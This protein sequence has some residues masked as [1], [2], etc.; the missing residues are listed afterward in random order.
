MKPSFSSVGWVRSVILSATLLCGGWCWHANSQTNSWTNS[1]SGYWEDQYWLMGL[2]P[3]SDQNIL[4]TNAG[5]KALGIGPNT[6]QNFPQTFTV[7]SITISSPANSF[8]TLLLNYAG[9]QTP[10]TARALT[11][12]SN[13]AVVALSSA[14]Q[15][16]GD[17]L[18]RVT[19]SIGGTFNQGDFSTV[20]AYLMSLG[21][22]G[23][24]VY[25]LTNGL[26]S[27]NMEFIGGGDF[28]AVFNHFG[29]TNASSVRLS[30][31]GE[32][33]LFDGY[34]SGSVALGSFK[35]FGGVFS[36]GLDFNSGSYRLAGG[37][38]YCSELNVPNLSPPPGVSTA[39]G[40][41]VQTGG[42]NFCGPIVIYGGNVIPLDASGSYTLSNG[43]LFASGT[44]AVEGRGSFNQWG[45]VNTNAGVSLFWR[46]HSGGRGPGRA[47]LGRRNVLNCRP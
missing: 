19:F 11:V 10:L 21:D 36:G 41:F 32:Y 4:F 34:F 9:F 22:I 31:G 44:I 1:V 26:V 14:L 38:F 47:D 15:V 39:D 7:R 5:W 2:L 8:N 3:G 24:G 45:G 23:P 42:T 29:G 16:T 43:A 17:G 13:S 33:D 37:T 18:G 6:A 30:H 25:N 12:G 40:Y 27:M 28:P 46:E 20:T 35:Q